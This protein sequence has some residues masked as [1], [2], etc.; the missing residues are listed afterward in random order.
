M[1][2]NEFLNQENQKME[3]IYTA[4]ITV[5][6]FYTFCE[7]SYEIFYRHCFDVQ[8]CRRLFFATSVIIYTKFRYPLKSV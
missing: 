2:P 7:F 4:V 5:L 8:Y 1:D 3:K 6:Y